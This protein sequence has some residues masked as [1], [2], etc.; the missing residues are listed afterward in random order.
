M[1]FR[2]SDAPQRSPEWF[3]IRLGKVTASR[4]EEFLARSKRDGSPLKS[5]LDYMRELEFERTFD[6]SFEV[7][8]SQPMMDGNLYEDFGRKQY[9]LLTGNEAQK[10]GCWYND[11]FVASPDATVDDKGLVEIKMLKDNSFTD[12]LANGVPEKHWKQIQGQLWATGRLW[13][14]YVAINLNS[15][16][17]SIIR[18]SPDKQFHKELEKALDNPV[19][20]EPFQ[21]GFL[22]DIQGEIPSR[23]ELGVGFQ[24]DDEG[25]NISW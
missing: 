24:A 2:Y 17:V 22:H 15:K 11:K 1:E 23:E 18:V 7:W 21:T 10:C 16:K 19:E 13:C 6:T 5:C 14:D 20:V 12:V 3:K 9:H 25:V 4:L 8:V